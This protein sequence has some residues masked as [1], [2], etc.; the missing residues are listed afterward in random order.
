MFR[1]I[2]FTAALALIAFAP[3]AI[4]KALGALLIAFPHLIGAPQPSQHFALAPEALQR[5]FAVAALAVSGIFW[6]VLG[7]LCGCLFERFE[8]A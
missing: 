2:V 1:R 8:R 6:V 7:G 5:Q 4:W 3:G